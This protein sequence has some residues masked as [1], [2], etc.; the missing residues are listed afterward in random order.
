MYITYEQ[1]IASQLQD[2]VHQVTWLNCLLKFESQKK[3]FLIIVNEFQ[4]PVH[5]EMWLHS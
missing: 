5:Q 1:H 2:Y 3:Q 4:N